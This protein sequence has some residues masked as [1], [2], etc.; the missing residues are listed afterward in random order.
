MNAAVARV[1]RLSGSLA[2]S[3][4]SAIERAASTA[5]KCTAVSAPESAVLTKLIPASAG[6]RMVCE[7]LFIDVDAC[8]IAFVT[9]PRY[10]MKRVTRLMLFSELRTYS[11]HERSDTDCAIAT[12][13]ATIAR[14]MY[15]WK[16]RA[17][18]SQ[19]APL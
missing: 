5:W 4:S 16:L 2:R 13:L 9:A 15:D 10:G 8:A 7:A 12:S 3:V 6:M 17:R 11:V 18:A 1:V 19:I 14:F